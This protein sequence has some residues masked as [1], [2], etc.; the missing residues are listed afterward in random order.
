VTKAGQT[1]TALDPDD[2]TQLRAQAHQM[3]DDMLDY[4]ANIRERPV[5]VPMPETV[6]Q[7]FRA[8]IPRHPVPLDAVH[9]EFMDYVLPYAGGNVHPGFMGWVQGGGTAIGMI[10]EMLAGGLN[11]NLGGRDHAPIEVERQIVAWVRQL[12]GFPPEASGLFLTGTSMANL[13][14]VL[15]ARTVKLGKAARRDGIGQTGGQ[16]RAYASAAA[17][18]CIAQAMDLAGFG[19]DA[20]RI[21]PV[22]ALSRMNVAAL[23]GMIAQDRA[24]GLQ[25]FL[26]VGS[27]GTVDVGAVDDLK[28]IAELCRE[29]NLWFHIDGA[30]GALGMLSPLVA[31][32]LDGIGQADSIAF[33]F[34]KWGQVPYDAGF[35]LVRDGRQHYESFASPAAYLRRETSG[36]AAGSPW[37]CDFG[38]DLSRGFRALKT[39]F[40]LKVH[41]SDAIGAVITRSCELAHYLESRVRA[42]AA[43]ELLAGAQLNIVCFRYRAP[44]SDRVNSEIVAS[45][46]ESGISAPSMTTING[47]LAIRAALF[48]HRSL[49]EDVDVLID[50]TLRLGQARAVSANGE[51]GTITRLSYFRS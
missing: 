5:W 29:Q 18:G 36:L 46:H 16:L 22:D 50:A 10:A 41:G 17:H 7:N 35:L 26:I 42:E 2:W 19:S 43:L 37:P 28:A 11:A 51:R 21:V 24:A 33:D 13:L 20:L 32:R 8:E 14:A 31:P 27:A 45:L 34:H 44:D 12:F 3:L 9:R 39:W 49:K 30:Y 38:P 15:V 47:K 40:T 25:P 6:R 1:K 4:V 23:R 48:N